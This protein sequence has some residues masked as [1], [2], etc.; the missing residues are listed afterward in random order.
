MSSCQIN[1]VTYISFG[2]TWISALIGHKM[3]SAFD[4]KSKLLSIMVWD[5]FAISG[6]GRLASIN[7]KMNGNIFPR[8]FEI[9]GH[10]SVLCWSDLQLQ[11]TFGSAKGGQTSNYIWSLTFPTLRHFLDEE[12]IVFSNQFMQ[13]IPKSSNHFFLQRF[14]SILKCWWLM[15]Q[16]WF[17]S[18]TEDDW[19]ATKAK[20]LS[21]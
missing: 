3:W 11:E 16:V 2:I 20:L 8:H 10:L 19:S 17:L 9:W 4:P 7:R 5:W 1:A 6:P 18:P 14:Y 15:Y 21:L 13:V 12:E